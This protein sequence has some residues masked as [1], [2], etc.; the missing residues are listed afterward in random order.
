MFINFLKELQEGLTED[1]NT[2]NLDWLKSQFFSDLKSATNYW[3]SDI[4][5]KSAEVIDNSSLEVKATVT[6]NLDKIDFD[7]LDGDDF[8]GYSVPDSI[9]EKII[10]SINEELIGESIFIRPDDTDVIYECKLEDYDFD[11]NTYVKTYSEPQTY[12]DPGY[13]DW[14]IN[15][16]FEVNVELKLTPKSN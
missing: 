10:E 5:L 1:V 12:D 4:E 6:F 14:E 11:N 2:P 9:G 3:G 8:D 16:Y 7:D 13:F 15:G